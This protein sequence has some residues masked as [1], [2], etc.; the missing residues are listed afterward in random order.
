MVLKAF[1]GYTGACSMAV[2]N[3][4][5]FFNKRVEKFSEE[6]ERFREELMMSLDMG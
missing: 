3:E 2:M 6:N 4:T 1:I 5:V